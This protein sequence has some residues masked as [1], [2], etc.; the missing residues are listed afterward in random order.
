MIP[1]QIVSQP[2]DKLIVIFNK[3]NAALLYNISHFFFS[4]SFDISI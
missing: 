1:K 3:N 4:G 2:S